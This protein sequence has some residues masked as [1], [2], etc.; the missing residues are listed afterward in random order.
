MFKS[1]IAL[2]KFICEDVQLAISKSNKLM[3]LIN[4]ASNTYISDNV[5]TILLQKCCFVKFTLSENPSINIKT[6][7][8]LASDRDIIPTVKSYSHTQLFQF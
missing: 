1:Y 4:L 8:A 3:V 7:L 2:N 6:K 5:Q